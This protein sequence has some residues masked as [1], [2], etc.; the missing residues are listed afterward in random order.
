LFFLYSYPAE[1]KKDGDWFTNPLDEKDATG[2][3][4]RDDAR[5]QRAVCAADSAYRGDV[6]VQCTPQH[7]KGNPEWQKVFVVVDGD[8]S[9]LSLFADES[10]SEV[11]YETS[12]LGAAV[13]LNIIH[14]AALSPLPSVEDLFG[15][16][17][18]LKTSTE[19]IMLCT[20]SSEETCKLIVAM[21]RS[22]CPNSF[23]GKDDFVD[24]VELESSSSSDQSAVDLLNDSM[25]P[26]VPDSPRDFGDTAVDDF[27]DLR[28]DL[29]SNRMLQGDDDVKHA[30]GRLEAS[31]PRFAHQLSAALWIGTRAS[32]PP[33]AVEMDMA[34]KQQRGQ[35]RHRQVEAAPLEVPHQEFLGR[36]E[37]PQQRAAGREDDLEKIRHRLKAAAYTQGGVDVESLFKTSLD[38][39]HDGRV[40]IDEFLSAVRRRLHI[41]TSEIS[42][43]EVEAIFAFIDKNSSETIELE[44]IV[45]FLRQGKRWGGY[46]DDEQ[47]ARSIARPAVPPTRPPQKLQKN[48]PDPQAVH[49]EKQEK[50]LAEK[51]RRRQEL[52]DK[53]E[54]EHRAKEEAFK[55]KEKAFAQKELEMQRKMEQLQFEKNPLPSPS[56]S[57]S[58][59]PS[60]APPSPPPLIPETAGAAGE[61]KEDAA[62]GFVGSK[63]MNES[64]TFVPTILKPKVEVVTFDDMVNEAPADSPQKDEAHEDNVDRRESED[65]D[66]ESTA[67][68]GGGDGDGNDDESDLHLGHEWVQGYDKNHGHYYYFN[69][70]TKE[71]RWDA[72]EEYLPHVESSEEEEESD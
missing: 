31:D 21:S 24:K 12:L 22:S 65:E 43:D 45:A 3:D 4:G 25:L 26:R 67:E 53:L 72:P 39:N 1:P 42:D 48:A 27:G 60:V 59:P 50:E 62:L 38:V 34:P 61:A 51:I 16:F 14:A 63:E 13:P 40:D 28:K 58:P 15:V 6:Y 41:P 52:L 46:D 64:R 69:V 71:S 66:E 2:D 23:T 70:K 55:D 29:T 36:H 11:V 54:Q 9:N 10:C 17:L 19:P 18:H 49:L 7:E 44:E 56:C 20:T 47:N 33:E 32:P 35:R 30:L 68:D 8:A 5:L 37:A 57:P